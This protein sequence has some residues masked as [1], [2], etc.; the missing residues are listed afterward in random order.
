[1]LVTSGSGAVWSSACKR[2]PDV[3]RHYRDPVRLATGFGVRIQVCH[4]PA[5]K[6]LPVRVFGVTT[7]GHCTRLL[8]DWEFDPAAGQFARAAGGAEAS[9]A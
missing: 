3:A 2:R 7:A 6:H 9:P 5:A 4:L 8:P 1:M